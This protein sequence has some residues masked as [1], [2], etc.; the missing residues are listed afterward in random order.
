MILILIGNQKSMLPQRDVSLH[1]SDAY[2][3][4]S[5]SFYTDSSAADAPT[6]EPEKPVKETCQWCVIA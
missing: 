5:A 4:D 2:W 1:H 6:T 3:M